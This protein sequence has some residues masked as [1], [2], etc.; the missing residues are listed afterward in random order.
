MGGVEVERAE[1]VITL[2]TSLS[3]FLFSKQILEKEFFVWD[4]E[5]KSQWPNGDLS[6]MSFLTKNPYTPGQ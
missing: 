1:R 6:S 3:N 2:P 4:L 5:A